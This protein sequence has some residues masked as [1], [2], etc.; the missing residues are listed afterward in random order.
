MESQV[1]ARD[2]FVAEFILSKVEGLLAM[3]GLCNVF[4]ETLYY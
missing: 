4:N 1:W 2:C 3:A